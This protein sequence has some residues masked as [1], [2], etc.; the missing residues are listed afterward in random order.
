MRR[1]RDEQTWR[2]LVERQG[3]SGLSVQEFCRRE[4][5]KAWSLYRW[6][7]RL[8]ARGQATTAPATP[9]IDLGALESGH[10]RCEVR[11]EL[12]GGVVLHVVR[13]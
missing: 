4:G 6:R 3:Q 5:V 8:R 1:G 9:F 12:G 10:E 13:G 11:I 2:D 7:S